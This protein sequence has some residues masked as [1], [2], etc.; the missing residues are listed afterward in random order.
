MNLRPRFPSKTPMTETEFAYSDP[1]L[2]ETPGS[3]LIRETSILDDKAAETTQLALSLD[4]ET[5]FSASLSKSVLLSREEELA[6]TRQ[7]AAARARVGRVL[8]QARRLTRAA[9]ADAGR[10]VVRPDQSFRERETLTILNYAQEHLKD[11][12]PTRSTGMQRRQL[13]A[14]V[15]A[16]TSALDQYR[17]LRNQMVQA[18]IRLV[19]AIARQYHH[20]T[21]TF[22]DLVQEGTIGLLRAI[23]KYD[24]DRMVKFSTYAAWWIW[25][26]IARTADT[27]GSLIRTPVHWNQLRRQ[28]SRAKGA[29]ASEQEWAPTDEEVASAQ[30]LDPARIAAMTQ[31]YHFLSLDAPLDDDDERP[32]ESVIADEGLQPQEQLLQ[33]DLRTR[34]TEAIGRLPAREAAIVRHRF[35]MDG[36]ETQTLGEIG[37]QFGVSRE[38]IR[39]LES[40]A[41]K[42]LREL[43][44]VQG[45]QEYLH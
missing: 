32:L 8:R 28:V 39:Q 16:L 7:I 3:A 40:R 30:G 45:L 27:Q 19:S 31:S 42:Q 21:L 26:Q 18:N 33:A 36:D 4:A 38:R 9:L 34:L 15:S 17:A 35:G 24:P 43:C 1:M 20:P 25:Q 14:F 10:G 22:L 2:E 23:E 5:L 37:E 12:R 44:G 6:L 29:L 41:L 13:R 11:P